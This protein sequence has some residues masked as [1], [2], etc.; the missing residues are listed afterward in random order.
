[1]EKH[2]KLSPTLMS[3]LQHA[4]ELQS[5]NHCL[6]QLVT[7][8]HGQRTAVCFWWLRSQQMLSTSLILQS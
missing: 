4:C 8:T 5:N 2:A 7:P 3:R 1:M 6:K